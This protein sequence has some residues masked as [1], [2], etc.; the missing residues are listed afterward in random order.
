MKTQTFPI[1]GMHC[2]SCSTILERTFKKIP[3][4]QTVAVNYG[5]E[6][7]NLTY[8][9]TL[10][11][12]Q[13]LSK[14]IEPLGYSLVIPDPTRLDAPTGLSSTQ[15]KLAELDALKKNVLAILPLAVISIAIMGWD[16]SAQFNLIPEMS[17]LWE[18]FFHHLLPIMATYSLFVVGKPYLLGLARFLR[19]GR[20]NMDTLIG[21]GTAT[22]FLF[23][24]LVSAFEE[25]V[26]FFSN[27]KYTYYDVTIV[28]IAFVT[29]GKYLEA[30]SKQR[31]GEA[32]TKL[33]SLQAKTARVIRDTGEIEI[34]LEQVL[35][36]DIIVVKP[37]EK[38]PVD[39]IITEGTT[40]IDE[41]MI[42][43]ES[44][45]VDRRPGEHVIGATINQQGIIRFRAT[46]VG[47]DT[48][49]AHIITLVEQAQNSKAPIQ[50]LADTISSVFVPVV[51]GIA[52]IAFL[53]WIS[54]GTATLG[55]SAALSFGI[56]SFVSILVIAC[57]CALGLATPTALIVGIGKGAEN[58]I[59]IKNAEGLELLNQATTLVFDKTGTLTEGRPT[60]TAIIP[61]PAHTFSEYIIAK[62]AARAAINSN[63]P[64][65][66]AIVRHAETKAIE[67]QPFKHF[68]EIPG[69]GITAR[70]SEHNEPI[71][72]GNK[73]LLE[74]LDMDT[75]WANELL[76]GEATEAGTALFVV[77]HHE[78]IGALIVA[79]TI[80]AESQ[81]AVQRLQKM[82]LS[83][84]MITGDHIRTAQA[85]AKQIGIDTVLADVLPQDKAAAIKKLQ[86]AGEI[87][88]M[89][90]DGINDSPA[91]TQANIGIA[92]AT[93]SDIAI[94]S[95]AIT[96][97]HGDIRKI[98][99]AIELSRMTVRTIRQNLFW[100]FI[101]NI[102]GIP[103]AA[104]LLYPIW[105][106]VLSPVFAGMA[107]A[108]S[109]VSVV[110][111]SL[112]LKTKS[113]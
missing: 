59:L 99:Q 73:K 8:D 55:F 82:G 31:T 11:T 57:P 62:V 56:V 53:L 15:E 81:A 26:G 35:V 13:D 51:L 103:I 23:S 64:L 58:G 27:I 67:I 48:L 107:M 2:A 98:A 111:N 25:S 106:I 102:I 89:A 49:L 100:A 33:L 66:Q 88:A 96:L 19:H 68:E 45:P 39:G 104:G 90:G 113:L 83:V 17:R 70:C 87:V 60:V 109:S 80:K 14:I 46:K 86:D 92:M 52:V 10:A 84:C 9:D 3:T 4:I 20:A 24:F 85:I 21:L 79:D 7:V 74:H 61:N 75:V 40:A 22:A 36:G 65:S 101:Y 32:I 76:A 30:R 78:V 112:R 38:I 47:G 42:T 93:G 34:P 50:A 63:H 41:A 110:T 5:T 18:E 95:A 1:R 6:N 94:E 108:F 37:G 12:P 16:I 54:I 91:L 105:G 28:V 77:H 72:V 44:M 69:K 71:A 43:G 29:L 97:L